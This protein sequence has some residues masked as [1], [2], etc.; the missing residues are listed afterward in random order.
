MCSYD[1]EG[2]NYPDPIFPFKIAFEPAE[3]HFQ[4]AKPDSMETFMAQFDS[5]AIGTTVYTLKAFASPE[6]TE[7]MNFKSLNVTESH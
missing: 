6:D 3:V 4:E 7:G 2:T 5:V 1:Q